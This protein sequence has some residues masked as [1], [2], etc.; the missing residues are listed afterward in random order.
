MR[1]VALAAG[2]LIAVGEPSALYAHPL[3]TTLTG[4]TFDRSRH[5]VR[6]VVRVFI[7]DFGRAVAQHAHARSPLDVTYGDA[8]RYVA[9]SF[10]IAGPNSK[11][12]PLTSCGMRRT[13]D[14]MWLCMETVTPLGPDQLNVRDHVLCDLYEDQVNIVQVALGADRR[15]ILFTP[16][17]GFKSLR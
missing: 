4:I 2:F 13:G 9:A 6:A 11:P 14:L 7:D 1:S 10:A 15:T 12:L 16:D 17:D 5:A 3:H 8:L